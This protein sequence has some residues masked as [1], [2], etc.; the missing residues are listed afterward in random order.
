MKPTGPQDL[1]DL[2]NL[3]KS[4]DVRGV[5][6]EDLTDE[7]ATAIGAAFADEIVV[8]DG[9]PAVAIGTICATRDRSLPQRWP[10]V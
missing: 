1:P 2:S 7:I 8:P 4:Y 3:I 10:R 5:V 6:G 9:A